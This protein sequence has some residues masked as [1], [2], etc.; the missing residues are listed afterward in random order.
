[1]ITATWEKGFE[2]F[3][4]ADAQKVAEEIMAIGESATP[5]QIVDKAKDARSELHRC[6]TWDNNIAADKWRLHE[7][8]TLVCHLV[9]QTEDE[10]EE[11]P[12]V[13]FF[14]RI[15]GGGYKQLTR[16]FR[17]E[18][19]YQALLRQAYADL[20]ALKQ[21]YRNLQELDWLWDQ[22]S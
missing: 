16:I 5:Q 9:I 11:V 3:H 2:S 13:R 15:D 22:I 10:D 14:H 17:R 7:A 4:K 6:F 18:D 12:E 8:R 1:M 21:K 20:A 19:E